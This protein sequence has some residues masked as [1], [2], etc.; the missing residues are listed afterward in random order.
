MLHVTSSSLGKIHRA[1]KV[2]VAVIRPSHQR[3]VAGFGPC[4]TLEEPPVIQG[5]KGP[6]SGS[7]TD[8]SDLRD[9][10]V[11][12]AIFGECDESERVRAVESD[13]S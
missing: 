7:L 12:A 3:I 2:S 8:P 10:V 1:G 11:P 9:Q 13:V 5:I 6:Q 4:S